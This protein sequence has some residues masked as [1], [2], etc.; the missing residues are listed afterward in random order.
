MPIEEFM[1]GRGETGKQPILRRPDGRPPITPRLIETETLGITL[2]GM[3]QDTPP[4]LNE[5]RPVV[6]NEDGLWRATKD[7]SDV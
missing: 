4:P 3:D 1:E 7:M 2:G 5:D 6:E